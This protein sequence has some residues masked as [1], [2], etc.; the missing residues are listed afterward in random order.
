MHKVKIVDFQCL[1]CD[2]IYEVFLKSDTV[3]KCKSCGADEEQKRLITFQGYG[4]ATS[5]DSPKT[6]DDLLN[7][8]GNGQYRPG[9]KKSEWKRR[10]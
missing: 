6:K 5:D 7:Y 10:N 2:N 9:Y 3:P 8:F 4:A 1:K